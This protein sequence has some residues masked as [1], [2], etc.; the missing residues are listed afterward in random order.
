MLKQCPSKYIYRYTCIDKF[1]YNTSS[2]KQI[3]KVEST[4]NAWIIVGSPYF[5]E[6]YSAAES[7]LGTIDAEWER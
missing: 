6:I 4:N 5:Q 7:I 3:V 1:N 2:L